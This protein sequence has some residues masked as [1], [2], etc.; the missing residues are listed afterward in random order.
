MSTA[1]SRVVLVAVVLSG[2]AA[3]L[4]WVPAPPAAAH[5]ELLSSDPSESGVLEALPSR[6]ILT[7]SGTVAEVH[8]VTVTGPDG[9]VANGEASAVGAEVRQNLWAGPDGAY[10]LT[11]DVLSSD[12]HEI[13]GE[14]HFEVGDDAPAEVRAAATSESEDDSDGTLRGV[15]VPA[16][17]VLLSGACALVIRQRRR[18]AR[19]PA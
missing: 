6:A 16:A 1:A 10:T 8:E 5:E 7:F 3:L 12:G 2:L 19:E 18:T 14:I 15:V 11:Y 4:V 9:S 13:A 17:V